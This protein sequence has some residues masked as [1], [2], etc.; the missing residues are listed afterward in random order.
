VIHGA[1]S[2]GQECPR[3]VLSPS[4]RAAILAATSM[5]REDYPGGSAVA[6]CGKTYLFAAGGPDSFDELWRQAVE[7]RKEK[8]A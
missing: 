1:N 3:P 7:L 2:G 6:R 4:E 5:E 8:A